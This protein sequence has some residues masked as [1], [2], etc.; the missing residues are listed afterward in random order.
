[1]YVL[2]LLLLWKPV[3][4]THH[5]LLTVK[6]VYRE[7]RARNWAVTNLP[8]GRD[9]MA[10]F[11]IDFCKSMMF[12]V[13]HCSR[14]P[15]KI[16][17]G[18]SATRGSIVVIISPLKGIITT[19][20]QKYYSST[21]QQWNG[22]L[23]F[24]VIEDFGLVTKRSLAID[25]CAC[26]NHQKLRWRLACLS[27]GSSDQI[28]KFK[29]VLG[30]SPFAGIEQTSHRTVLFWLTLQWQWLFPAKFTGSFLFTIYAVLL[31]SRQN[32][33]SGCQNM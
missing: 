26:L 8:H 13:F 25:A 28:M 23:M 30:V 9:V 15:D 27:A 29:S 32:Q 10:V 1:M 3:L 20:F 18:L 7:T 12:T 5:T 17:T 19:K 33:W 6:G 11:P 31:Q 21:S 4:I 2:Q 22:R 16:C 14:S 24:C